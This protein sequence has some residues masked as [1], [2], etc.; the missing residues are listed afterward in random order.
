[1]SS[2]NRLSVSVCSL[3]TSFSGISLHVGNFVVPRHF[4]ET[5]RM[6]LRSSRVFF[7]ERSV[8]LAYEVHDADGHSQV[9]LNGSVISIIS[10]NAQIGE[11]WTST[12]MSPSPSTGVGTCSADIPLHWFS[13]T[14]DVTVQV[15]VQSLYNISAFTLRQSNVQNV[16]LTP[17]VSDCESMTTG[18]IVHTPGHP[19]HTGESFSVSVVANVSSAG[20]SYWKF[21]LFFDPS[22]LLY[23]GYTVSDAFNDG[24]ATS[25]PN[26]V[27]VSSSGMQLSTNISE[28]S[29]P[30]V[31]L[32]DVVFSV[33]PSASEGVYPSAM[34]AML[35][36][37]TTDDWVVLSY[38]TTG[39]FC[40][41]QN[42]TPSSSGS[43][44]INSTSVAGII[45]YTEKNEL[46]NTAAFT[47]TAQSSVIHVLGVQSSWL[48][49]PF[50]L[51]TGASVCMAMSNMTSQMLVSNCIVTVGAGQI[52]GADRA[53][54]GVSYHDYFT[55]VRYKIW[56][57]LS[58]RV[59][60]RDNV[61]NRIR[62]NT[63]TCDAP[64]PAPED[65][66]YFMS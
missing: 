13:Y 28:V 20:A 18:I 5:I 2:K 58:A 29:G 11:N 61:L 23:T 65:N 25:Y 9:Q 14:E 52:D 7:D 64:R 39:L 51:L 34:Q 44:E 3:A 17:Y 35:Q 47:G 6:V 62:S 40:N 10:I 50:V 12:C 4:I 55:T 37:L 27:V 56:T 41:G 38:N 30:G 19:L 59:F 43:L 45:A 57:P 48:T 8:D 36:Y 1:M 31:L 53:L 63:T 24:G 16:T 46:L 66:P 49:G 33:S 22:I 15:H 42:C 60:A 54:V 32:A 26:S 21:R